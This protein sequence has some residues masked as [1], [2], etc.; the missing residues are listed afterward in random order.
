M[1]APLSS[2]LRVRIVR[3]VEGG[4][5]IRQAALRYEVAP[6]T[7]VKLMRRVRATG[8]TSPARY[9]GHRR[10]VLEPHTDLLRALVDAKSSTTLAEL[11]AALAARGIRVAALSTIL[12]MLRR[13]G[14]SHKKSR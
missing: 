9:G 13:L 11:Q 1:P 12:L 5:S 8:S 2:D 7:A 3:A 14:L 4:A 6:S 10:P